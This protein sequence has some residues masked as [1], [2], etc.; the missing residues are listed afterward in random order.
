MQIP[1]RDRRA[2]NQARR[3]ILQ[4]CCKQGPGKARV[5]A[6]DGGAALASVADVD[7]W[8]QSMLDVQWVVQEVLAAVR[9]EQ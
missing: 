8:V 4:G 2:R 3:R 1:A 9:R 7:D 5:R 6:R